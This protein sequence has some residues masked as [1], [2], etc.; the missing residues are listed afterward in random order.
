MGTAARASRYEDLPVAAW[1]GL[2]PAGAGVAQVAAR[3]TDEA[4]ARQLA[5]WFLPTR[6]DPEE[7]RPWYVVVAKAG[8]R[9]IERTVQG[10]TPQGPGRRLRL[11]EPGLASQFPRLT[12]GTVDGPVFVL[13]FRDARA[14]WQDRDVRITPAVARIELWSDSRP[15]AVTA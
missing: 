5:R 11:F 10:A 7:R 9:K 6:P 12:D 2:C 3:A 4:W 1:P 15:A 8:M 13:C 14:L